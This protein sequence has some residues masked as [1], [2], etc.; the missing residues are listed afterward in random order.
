MKI[1][2]SRGIVYSLLL[3]LA[4]SIGYGIIRFFSIGG[5]SNNHP[6]MF[7]VIG[8]LAIIAFGIVGVAVAISNGIYLLL[9]HW[10]D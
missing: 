7:A 1:N 10:N 8:G 6:D 3:S 9:Q 5:F 4:I 2:A